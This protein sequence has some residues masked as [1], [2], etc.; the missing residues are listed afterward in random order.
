M[1]QTPGTVGDGDNWTTYFHLQKQGLRKLPLMFDKSRYTEYRI[2]YSY[3]SATFS[4]FGIF[5][6]S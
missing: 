1:R 5:F 6:F 2:L 4:V 3:G